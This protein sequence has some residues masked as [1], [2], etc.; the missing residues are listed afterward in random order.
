MSGSES[1][2]KKNGSDG[3]KT[4]NAEKKTKGGDDEDLGE[5]SI[6]SEMSEMD[7]LNRQENVF[8]TLLGLPEISIET[9]YLAFREKDK[10]ILNLMRE[11]TNFI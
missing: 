11:Q 7:I 4:S 5:P 3:G 6:N 10:T 1:G 2:S 9:L 8:Q